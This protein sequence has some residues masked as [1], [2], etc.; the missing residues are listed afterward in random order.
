MTECTHFIGIGGSGI[1]AIARLLL[2]SGYEV[3][4]SD[5]TLSPL[6]AELEKAGQLAELGAAK[7]LKVKAGKA[8]VKFNLPRQGVSLL[9]LT[10][11]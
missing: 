7:T 2:E 3:T 5:R 9:V 6:A 10:G 1:S 4:G 11:E 8:E